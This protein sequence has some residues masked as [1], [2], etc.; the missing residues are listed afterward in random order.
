VTGWR[1]RLVEWRDAR[2]LAVMTGQILTPPPPSA[3][4]AFGRNTVVV[5]PARVV[6]PEC[7][8]L[9]DDVLI[10]EHCML[11]VV[12]LVPGVEPRLEI[13][14]GSNIGRLFSVA[15][16][17]EV[18]IGANVLTAERVFIADTFHG[19][20]DPD[21]PII[22]QPMAPGRPV[23]VG[24]GAFLGIGSCILGGVTIGENAYVG[25]GAVVTTDVEP[26][27]VVVGNPARAVRRVNPGGPR[28]GL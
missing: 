28:D 6:S 18:I 3:Y 25:A 7:T 21:R 27:T 9:G 23:V 8:F 1:D 4:G 11:S 26:R 5:P 13:G 15:C 14:S 12:R 17:G 2:R 16:V 19:Y 20:D 10:H 22:D 24:D